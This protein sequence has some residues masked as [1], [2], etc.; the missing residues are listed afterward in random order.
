MPRQKS[1]LWLLKNKCGNTD[2]RLSELTAVKNTS[3]TLRHS[4]ETVRALEAVEAESLPE[5][6]V[7]EISATG[8]LQ[9]TLEGQELMSR[10]HKGKTADVA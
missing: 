7:R 2:T 4:L 8:A 1:S 10:T 9:L 3:D 6:V 5:L